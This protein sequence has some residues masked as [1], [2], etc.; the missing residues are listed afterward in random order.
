M[1]RITITFILQI[2]LTILF[3]VGQFQGMI[4][5]S[6]IWVLSPLWIPFAFVAS[7]VVSY[8]MIT[9][10]AAMVAFLLLPDLDED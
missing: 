1:K 8:L 5:W 3:I 4:D 10:M 6:W 7:L 2:V 9:A